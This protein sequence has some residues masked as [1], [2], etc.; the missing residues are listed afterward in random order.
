MKTINLTGSG[1][2]PG[3]VH[4]PNPNLHPLIF[5]L[6][7]PSIKALVSRMMDKF[8]TC[9]EKASMN[10]GKK[11]DLHTYF[12]NVAHIVPEIPGY[13]EPVNEKLK[14]YYVGNLRWKGFTNVYP[15]WW[16]EI[17]PDGK[18]I[19]LSFGGTGYDKEKLIQ[20][21]HLLTNNGFRV[22]VTSSHIAD[23]GEFHKNKN[24]FVAKFLP[25]DE[26]SQKVD[27]VLCHGGYGTIMDA[28]MA[29]KPSLSIPFNPDQ[30]LHALRFRELHLGEVL[31]HIRLKDYF[32]LTQANWNRFGEIGRSVTN[33][34]VLNAVKKMLTDISLYKDSLVSFSISN[35][36]F[37]QQL[38]I[39]KVMNSIKY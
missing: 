30:L 21:A 32:S 35:N 9:L 6:S 26:I 28:A 2:L 16:N 20:L 23:T 27:L 5:K 31:T 12:R 25:G 14:R 22:V 17:H 3:S 33:G 24:L 38:N 7:R 13:L 18:T 29:Y 36:Q 39:N 11:I 4:I 10:M 19:Y 37:T 15:S 34:E 8:Y 1:G